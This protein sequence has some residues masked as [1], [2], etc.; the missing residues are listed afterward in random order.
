MPPTVQVKV[1]MTTTTV[2]GRRV[3]LGAAMVGNHLLWALVADVDEPG[4]DRAA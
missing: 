4:G 3:L 1:T 2:E